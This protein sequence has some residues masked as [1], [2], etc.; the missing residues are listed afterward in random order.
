MCV[1]ALLF[2]I[3]IQ[4]TSDLIIQVEGQTIHVHKAILKIRCSYFRTMFQN[5][6]AE[7]SQR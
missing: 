4:T 6:W 5:N 7:N 2:F 1:C 3:I